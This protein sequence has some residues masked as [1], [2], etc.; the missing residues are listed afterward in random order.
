MGRSHG[1]GRGR[2]RFVEDARNAGLLQTIAEAR[3]GVDEER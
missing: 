1:S 2:E 3:E